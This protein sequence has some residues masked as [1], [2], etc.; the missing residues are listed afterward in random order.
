MPSRNVVKNYRNGAFFHAYN[1][2]ANGQAIFLDDHDRNW[3]MYEL[4][5]RLPALDVALVA[6]ALMPN[7][8][9]LVLK[10]LRDGGITR[11][12]HALSGT[13]TRRFNTRHNRYGSLFQ[14]KF[15]ASGPHGKEAARKVTA[16]THLNPIDLRAAEP[17]ER[18]EYS[19]H[20]LFT[21]E[22]VE[23]WFA[24]PIA[25]DLFPT[26]DSYAKFMRQSERRRK[27]LERDVSALWTPLPVR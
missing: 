4:T 24:K 7:H 26:D 21:G 22:R 16:Y 1:R 3:F 8:F 2:G 11:L 25:S 27:Q 13:Y 18:F 20:R 10:Q 17:W 19:S 12:M 14:G 15:K 5:S 23:T 6:F 9:H